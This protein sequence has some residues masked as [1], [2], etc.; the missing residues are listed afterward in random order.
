MGG[1]FVVQGEQVHKTTIT[2][3]YLMKQ[4]STDTYKYPK[5]QGGF[6]FKK[7]DMQIFHHIENTSKGL[8]VASLWF[9][10]MSNDGTV[11]F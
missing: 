7:K 1:V 5:L 4:N 3:G 6:I 9:P 8:V 10:Q 11:I 2:Y